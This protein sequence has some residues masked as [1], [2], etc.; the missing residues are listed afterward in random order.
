MV[1]RW[2]G[3]LILHKSQHGLL[4]LQ[5]SHFILQLSIILYTYMCTYNIIYHG[6]DS[7]SYTTQPLTFIV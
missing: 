4:S 6:H 3:A 1:A 2:M 5:F 7:L